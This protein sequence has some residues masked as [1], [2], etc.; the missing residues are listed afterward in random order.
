MTDSTDSTDG[1]A[2]RR[3]LMARGALGAW[4]RQGARSAFLL[5]PDWTGL[6]TIPV[7]LVFLILVPWGLGIFFQRLY[8][9]GPAWFY[10]PT[11]QTGWWTTAIM[12]WACWVLVPRTLGDGASSPPT[13]ASLFSMMAAQ[14]LTISVVLSLIFI[15][16]V[17]LGAD[18]QEALGRWGSWAIWLSGAVWQGIALLGLVWRSGARQP[19]PRILVG[20]LLVGM[21]VVNQWF[22]PQPYWYPAAPTTSDAREEPVKLTQEAMELQQTL[23]ARNL[24]GLKPQRENAIDVYAITFAPYADDDVFRRESAM[25]AGVMQ[26]RFGASGRTIQMVNHRETLREL[27][28]A[29]PLNLQRAIQRIAT[30]M[31]RDNDVLFI[32]LTSHGARDGKLVMR[33]WPLTIEPVTP[34]MLKHWLDDAGIRHRIVSVSACYSGS[35]IDPLADSGTLVMTAADSDHTS[36]GCGSGSALTYFGRAMFDEELRRTWSFETAHAAARLSIE[37]REHE[38]GKTDGFSNPQIRIGAEM[39]ERLARLESERAAAGRIP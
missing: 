16:M 24:E 30:L 35:W 1:S 17:R 11:L 26:E 27:P 5:K 9:S 25:V 4:W 2:D 29:T 21:L 19:A 12:L 18:L 14:S 38:A 31:D 37:R 39:R 15:P 20:A 7:N 32:H 6:Q 22:Q 33:F 36:F 10:W 8:I 28:W 3:E 23:L 13:A 34:Q